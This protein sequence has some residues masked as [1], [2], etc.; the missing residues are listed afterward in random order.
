MAQ[1]LEPCKLERRVVL[2]ELCTTVLQAAK[3]GQGEFYTGSAAQRWPV[4]LTGGV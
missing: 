1:Q 2:S 4:L 3:E